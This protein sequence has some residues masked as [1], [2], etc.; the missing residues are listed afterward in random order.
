MAAWNTTNSTWSRIGANATYNGVDASVNILQ[1][2]GA[3]NYLLTVG[4]FSNIND[5]VNTKV[6]QIPH[7]A[8]YKF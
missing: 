1:Y 5:S 7:Y 6:R 3:S 4:N 2:N 8:T